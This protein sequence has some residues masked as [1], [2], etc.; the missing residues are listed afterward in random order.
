M[1]PGYRMLFDL[2]VVRVGVH[3]GQADV[4]TEQRGGLVL[5]LLRATTSRH[6]DSLEQKIELGVRQDILIMGQ[7]MNNLYE[8]RVCFENLYLLFIVQLYIK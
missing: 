1:T 5:G 6:P 7:Y 4:V 3:G 2:V 8:Q